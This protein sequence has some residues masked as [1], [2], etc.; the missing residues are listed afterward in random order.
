M[1]KAFTLWPTREGI[2]EQQVNSDGIPKWALTEDTTSSVSYSRWKVTA[3]LLTLLALILIPALVSNPV[4]KW[5]A[6]YL[7]C[8]LAVIFAIV[9]YNTT[10]R[11]RVELDLAKHWNE[12]IFQRSG[13]SLWR[14]DWTAARDAVLKLLHSGE[15]DMQAYFAAHPEELRDIR[16]KVIIKDINDSALL[17]SGAANKQEVLGPLDRILPDVDDT[18][19]QWLVAFARGDVIY[20]SEAHL[21]LPDGT[22][23]D[24]LF[25]AALPRDMRGFKDILVV[26]LDITEYK[27]AQARIK[28]AEVEIMR[29][30]R[31]STMGALTA[32]IAHEVNSPLAAIVAS[33]EAA[34]IW[35]RHQ[36]P[37]IQEAISAMLAINQQAIRAR[38]V[39]DRTRSFVNHT[40]TTFKPHSMDSLVCEAILFIQRD[41][42]ALQVTTHMNVPEDLP[43]VLAD[44][45]NIQQVLINLVLNAAQAMNGKTLPKD[46]SIHARIEKNMMVVSV[47]DSGTGI[48]PDKLST[49]FEPFYTTKENGMGMGLVICRTCIGVHG[50]DLWVTNRPGQGATFHFSLPLADKQLH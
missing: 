4:L 21:T 35:L 2:S 41:L 49:I 48:E 10:T 25:S 16:K 11:L 19:L 26:D 46:V 7:A 45:I 40:Q 22:I 18:F 3:S 30:A 37:N 24:T 43:L 15:R 38:S 32:S 9:H 47:S 14:E 33:S 23:K 28:Q 20:Q 5:I 8:L 42:R 17:R 27:A 1:R 44:A 36:Q 31:I 12:T 39:V 6:V 13:I 34:L 50:G 29:A